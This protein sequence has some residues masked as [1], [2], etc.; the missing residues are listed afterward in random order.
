MAQP[1]NPWSDPG[2]GQPF[3]QGNQQWDPSQGQPGDTMKHIMGDVGIAKQGLS[4]VRTAGSLINK[5]GGSAPGWMGTVGKI[6]GPVGMGLGAYNLIKGGG[7]LLSDIGS[8]ASVG[9]FFGG[10][11]GMGIGAG[12]GALRHWIGGIGAPSHEELQGRNMNDFM[13]NNLASMGTPEEKAEAQK[14]GWAN[15]NDALNVIV[16][17][18]KLIH[19]GMDPQQ[20]D[21]QAQSWKKGMWDSEKGGAQSVYGATSPIIQ[22]MTQKAAPTYQQFNP[23][24]Q[25]AANPRS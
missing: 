20:A 6:A 24:G 18:N 23:S 19:G 25:W 14:A 17:R 10:P 5:F 3:V 4:G 7:S 12:V 16:M 11:I 2:Q 15:P 9:S 8:G 22:M 21:Q 1:N 13:T